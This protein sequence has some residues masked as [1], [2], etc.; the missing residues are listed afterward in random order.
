MEI[1]GQIAEL[2]RR[3]LGKN[4][5]RFDPKSVRVILF[6]GGKAI[7]AT[8]GDKLSGIGTREIERTGVEIHVSLIV[9]NVDADGVEV[10][11]PDGTV[12]RYEAKTK[13]WA[14]GVAASPLAKMLADASGAECDRAGRVKV[15]P[16]CSLQAIRRYSPSAT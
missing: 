6:D 3:A 7:L 5:R 4:S 8:F 1:A 15:E 14:A 10:K 11:E 2:A 12:Q 13:I 16:D 9:T